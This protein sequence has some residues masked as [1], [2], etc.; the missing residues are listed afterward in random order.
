MQGVAKVLEHGLLEH[1]ILFK[2][3]TTVSKA[4]LPESN[5]DV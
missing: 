3:I 4:L 5:Y 2:S 1:A